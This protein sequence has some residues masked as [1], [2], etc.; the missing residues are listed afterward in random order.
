MFRLQTFNL[1]NLMY[2]ISN[3]FGINNMWDVF[4]IF[5]D[6]GL[7]AF[8][9]YRLIILVKETRAW[10]LIKGILIILIAA[11]ISGYFGLQ[12]IAYILDQA[13]QYI[14]I[15]LVVIFQPELRRALEKIG[16]SRFRFFFEVDE[17]YGPDKTAVIVEEIV[18]AASQLSKAKTGALIVFER[19]TKV[20]EVI[21]TGTSLDSNISGHLIVNLFTPNTPLHD[22][23]VIIRKNKIMA[24]G[25]FLPLTDNLD[26]NQ[27]L[28]T[29]HRAA[30]G[31][32]EVSDSISV[33]VS[34][35]TG[36][37]SLVIAGEIFRGLDKNLLRELLQ[38][39]LVYPVDDLK[40]YI[41]KVKQK[42]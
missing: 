15:A 16:R 42:P 20:G 39:N 31:I 38:K 4:R 8:I 35:E 22:G 14:A 11:K 34:E 23:A 24:A 26:L 13:V 25:C 12:T 19:E 1:I 21:N 33:V 37:I 7:V 9:T 18:D 10:Q 30:I 5:L 3:N 32:T 36:Q 40:K 29:R 27:N 41:W 6:V 28:G 2:F 17:H